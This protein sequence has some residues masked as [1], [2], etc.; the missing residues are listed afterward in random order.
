[1]LRLAT[2]AVAALTASVV[3]A[4]AKCGSGAQCPS[5]A[6]CCSQYGECGTGAYCLGGCDPV[7]SFSLDSCTPEPICQSKN[8]NSFDSMDDLASNT[9]YLGNS[10]EYDW[11]YSGTP[12]VHDGNLVLTMGNGSVGTLVAYN[13]YIWYGKVSGTFKTSRDAGVVTA[14]ILLSDAK[15]EIDYEFIGVDLQTAQTN[16]YFQGI[17]DWHHG[18]NATID[19]NSF[20]NFHTYEIDWT[21]DAVTWY[22]DGKSVRVLK[23]EETY[24]ETTHQYM[25][26]QTPAR[27]ELSLWPGGLASNAQGVIEWAGGEIDWNSQ[28]MQNP[29][30]YYAIFSNISITCYD[31]PSWAPSVKDGNAYIYN[32]IAATN[33]TVQI[34][35]NNTV[36]ANFADT[37]LNM[38]ASFSTST[39][40]ASQSSSTIADSVP[41]QNGGDGAHSGAGFNGTSSSSSSS[42]SETSSSAPTSTGFSQGGGSNPKSGTVSVNENMLQSSI[43]AVLVAVVALVAL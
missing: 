26:P 8:F 4:G 13:H 12:I 1:M 33:N 17:P 24:N 41:G 18:V 28:D 2:L 39:A 42:T 30:Y 43:F 7:N 20:E 25:F 5:S 40:S 38:T 19:S 34:V 31:P 15:D 22:L 14:F 23:R 27:L 3:S 21:P 37:G 16:Y 6:P 11:V 9:K 29:G 36:L 35:K 32:N 10:T